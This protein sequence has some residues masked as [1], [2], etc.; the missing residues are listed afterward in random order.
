MNFLPPP[1]SPIA[2]HQVS[3]PR[4][5]LARPLSVVSHGYE[6]Q[7]TG[8]TIL[9]VA[10]LRTVLLQAKSP[11]QAVDQLRGLYLK[12]G[13]FLV[14]IRAK[15]L[16]KRK[17]EIQIIE[18]QVTDIHGSSLIQ[19]FFPDVKFRS[20]VNQQSLVYRSILASEFSHRNGKNLQIGFSP[21][22]NPGGSVLDIAQTAIPGFI[23]ISG[24]VYF[25]N[26]GSRYSSRYLT[27]GSINYLPGMG[28]MLSA[29][30]SQG[31]PSL[32]EAS[33]GSAFSAAQFGVSSVTPWGI[34][35]LSAQWTHYRIGDVAFPLNPTGT[36]FVWSATGT[37]LLYASSRLRWSL[38]EGFNHVQNDVTVYKSLIPG[39]YP[40]TRQKYNYVSLGT[41]GNYSYSIGSFPGSVGFTFTYNQGVSAN[42]GTLSDAAGSPTANFHYFVTSFNV[43][44][45]LPLGMRASFSAMGQGA[46]NTLPQ[47]QQWVLGGFDNLSAWYPGILSGDNGYSG[48][49]QLIGPSWNFH[50][51]TVSLRTFVETGGAQFVYAPQG[52]NWRS[53]SDIGAGL[54]VA[55]PWGTQISAISALP[56]GWN[57][58]SSE[59]RKA[60]RTDVFF[61]LSQTF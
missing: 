55:T 31:L 38:T 47:Q 16:H 21:A 36:V 23:P 58:V 15:Y 34:Y 28:V 22:S 41:S 57:D 30:G 59:V 13:F 61:V 60:N 52:P 35:G 26:Y 42:H 49:L 11:Q 25:G 46:F 29:S 17:L 54:S 3:V 9:N 37:Q 4:H 51:Y 18:G 39:G 14:A 1:S 5:S 33:R 7:V 24:N 6:Y 50:R 27:G 40:L 43:N 45:S 20:N 53:L 19:S 2:I 56:L 44:Q 10:K 32:T 12:K 48:R 8:N